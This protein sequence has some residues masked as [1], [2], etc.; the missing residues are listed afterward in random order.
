MDWQEDEIWRV[1]RVV[2]L[3][4]SAIMG[5]SREGKKEVDTVLKSS[6]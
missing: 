1:S 6:H 5:R 4:G 3:E 2:R